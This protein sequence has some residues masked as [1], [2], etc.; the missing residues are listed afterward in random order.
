MFPETE[1]Q[2]TITTK[3]SPI[4]EVLLFVLCVTFISCGSPGRHPVSVLVNNLESDTNEAKEFKILLAPFSAI[5]T[6]TVLTNTKDIIVDGKTY[7]IRFGF[8][9]INPMQDSLFLVYIYCQAKQEGNFSL[10]P[11]GYFRTHNILKKVKDWDTYFRTVFNESKNSSTG[12][13]HLRKNV[14]L[15]VSRGWYDAEKDMVSMTVHMEFQ[16][17]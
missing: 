12:F 10:E 16:K 3:M 13:Y 1:Q 14:L 6:K 8:G 4:I 15:D 5:K 17:N 9:Y 2:S 11:Y 7:A